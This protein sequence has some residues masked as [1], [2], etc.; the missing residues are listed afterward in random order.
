MNRMAQII[1]AAG[2]KIAISSVALVESDTVAELKYELK[3]YGHPADSGPPDFLSHLAKEFRL[4]K[5]E[6][7]VI[8]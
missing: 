2:F 5:L 8:A 4:S 3:W 6:W 7:Q 1:R